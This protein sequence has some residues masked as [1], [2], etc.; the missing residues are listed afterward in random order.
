MVRFLVLALFLG[1]W[2]FSSHAQDPRSIPNASFPVPDRI[3][4][5]RLLWGTMISIH[6]ANT[7][8]NYTVLR[9]TGATEF[10]IQNSAAQLTETFRYLREQDIDLSA[11][12]LLAPEFTHAPMMAASDVLRLQGVFGLRPIAI[13]FDIYYKWQAGRW[14]VLSIGL[15]PLTL[16]NVQPE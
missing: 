7:S 11:T 12:L 16:Q 8:G 1:S 4:L 5:S 2:S 3:I 10:Q 14:K 6:D 13:Q 15:Q 9:D